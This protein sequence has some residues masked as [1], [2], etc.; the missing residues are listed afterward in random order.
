MNRWIEFRTTSRKRQRPE[1]NRNDALAVTPGANA[2]GSLS[3]RPPRLAESLTRPHGTHAMQRTILLAIVL[4][5]LGAYPNW[6]Q[7]P[8]ANPAVSPPALPVA[9][10]TESPGPAAVDLKA[11]IKPLEEKLL[12]QE[13]L[14]FVG[15]WKLISASEKNIKIADSD[16]M[17]FRRHGDDLEATVS[18]RGVNK[19]FTVTLTV[20]DTPERIRRI[21]LTE[22]Q[23][24]DEPRTLMAVY[25]IS[26]V[27]GEND[28]P[29]RLKMNLSKNGNYPASLDEQGESIH[30]LRFEKVL[31]REGALGLPASA[32]PGKVWESSG[33]FIVAIADDGKSASAYC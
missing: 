10:R 23:F 16:G 24:N 6:A 19:S 5:G 14:K 17:E 22:K 27:D 9:E 3:P 20:S 7:D 2:S 32:I 30:Q 18:Q 28:K 13:L 11:D 12:E 21:K 29:P 33:T 25:E 31:S 1:S 8:E 15:R 4:L 26:A